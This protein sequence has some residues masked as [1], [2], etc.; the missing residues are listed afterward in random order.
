[1]GQYIFFHKCIHLI[2]KVCKHYEKG[3]QA[4]LNCQRGPFHT[5]R[6]DKQLLY[7]VENGT[8]FRMGWKSGMNFASLCYFCVAV[9]ECPTEIT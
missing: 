6:N 9:T 8:G 4:S 2:F 1:V 5:E 7:K 3:P